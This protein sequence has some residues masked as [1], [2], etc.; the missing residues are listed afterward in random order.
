MIEL[1]GKYNKAK[2]FTDNIENQAVSQIIDLCNQSFVTGSNIAIMP[3]THAGAGCTIG[4]T[5]TLHGKVV[6]NLVGVDIGCGMFCVQLREKDIDLEVLDEVIKLHVPS[7]Q[8][9]RNED[10]KYNRYVDLNK[11]FCKSQVNLDRAKKSI[12]TLGGGNH[13]IELNKSKDGDLYLVVHSGSRYL[14]KQVAEYYQKLA[15]K[16]IKDNRDKKAEMVAKLKKE[17]KNKDIQGALK[18]MEVPKIP[19]SLCYL[20][21]QYYDEY[22]QDM[23][24]SQWYATMNREAIA[25]TIIERMGLNPLKSFHTIHNYIEINSCV[26]STTGCND[27]LRK[28]AISAADGEVVLIPINMRDGSILAIGKGNPEW[29]YSAPHGAGRILS[30]S[31][32][33]EQLTM[34]EFQDTMKDVYST[35]V[36]SSTLDE[37]PM[38]YKPIEEI[39]ENIVDTVEVIEVI[40]PIYNYKAH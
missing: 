20:E 32:A 16:S 38:A 36:C 5:M 10:H 12:G 40:K 24:L 8:N 34:A 33:K 23:R 14:G 9:V 29:N 21:G 30:R 6:P 22:L 7:G 37:A 28:G 3:D 25:D 27:I 13:F 31:K 26:T 1:K 18:S 15:I 4:T 11:L 19:D 2:V 35:S 17:G 39:L